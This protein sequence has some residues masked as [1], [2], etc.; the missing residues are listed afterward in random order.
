MYDNKFYVGDSQVCSCS[1]AGTPACLTC[2]NNSRRG[3]WDDY[4]ETMD[5]LYPIKDIPGKKVKLD[6]PR[7]IKITIE[8]E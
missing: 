8:F 1:L 7:R 4:K 5:W 2:V 6:Q 3:A